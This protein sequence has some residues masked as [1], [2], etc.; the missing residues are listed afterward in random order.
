ML[1]VCR[2]SAIHDVRRPSDSPRRAVFRLRARYK[3]VQCSRS[4]LRLTILWISERFEGGG[5]E[6]HSGGGAAG[7]LQVSELGACVLEDVDDL[8]GDFGVLAYLA[9]PSA[10]CVECVGELFH[11]WAAQR[12]AAVDVEFSHGFVAG[13]E[14]VG[15]A[16]GTGHGVGA[17]SAAEKFMLARGSL[18]S[19]PCASGCRTDRRPCNVGDATTLLLNAPWMIRCTSGTLFGA[20]DRLLRWD[21]SSRRR[22]A[23]YGTFSSSSRR[24]MTG[25]E[26]RVTR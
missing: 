15:E 14:G 19:T 24:A 10:G 3:S 20:R 2:E 6:L 5:V 11:A 25:S 7:D 13:V 1:R 26:N 16:V 18:W 9:E 4:K 12:L 21:E 23:L 8:D 17:I 22:T